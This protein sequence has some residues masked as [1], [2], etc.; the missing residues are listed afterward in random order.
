MS[1]LNLTLE[2]QR[3]QCTSTTSHNGSVGEAGPPIWISTLACG[4]ADGCVQI[5]SA[6]PFDSRL[7]LPRGVTGRLRPSRGTTSTAVHDPPARGSSNGPGQGK[8]DEKKPRRSAGYPSSTRPAY[9]AASAAQCG[10]IAQTVRAIARL[11]CTGDGEAPRGLIALGPAKRACE[12]QQ[13]RMAP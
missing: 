2:Q 13:Q 12:A 9:P 8:L 3:A 1:I 6:D 4:R 10:E 5:E 11:I 7:W